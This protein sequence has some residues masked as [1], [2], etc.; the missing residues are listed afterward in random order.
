MGRLPEDEPGEWVDG[1]LVEE[2][3]PEYLHEL[4][5]MWLGRIL[6]TW[7][8]SR[9]ALVAGSGAK[10]AVRSNRG[11]MPIDDEPV[12]APGLRWCVRTPRSR[13]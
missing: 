3:V 5:V 9:G 13:A 4:V 11:R 1:D 2:E 7:G 8:E 12:A 6:G 10:F